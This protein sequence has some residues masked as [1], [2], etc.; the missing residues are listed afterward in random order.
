ME[1]ITKKEFISI[2][3]SKE[4][5]NLGT[6]SQQKESKINYINNLLLKENLE[7]FL[8]CNFRKCKKVQTNALQFSDNSWYYFN[9]NGIKNY[10]K[11]NE[12]IYIVETIIDYSKDNQCSW[13]YTDYN[14]ITYFVK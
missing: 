8:K 14:Y 3:T 13:D 2:L 5:A 9:D 12:N 6:F 4:N 11:F 10:Y 7:R 1:R